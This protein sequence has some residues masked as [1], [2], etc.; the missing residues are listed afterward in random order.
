MEAEYFTSENVKADLIAFAKVIGEKKTPLDLNTNNLKNNETLCCNGE[1]VEGR[2][3]LNRAGVALGLFKDSKEAGN[4]QLSIL[5]ELLSLAGYDVKE[6]LQK[7]RKNLSIQHNKADLKAYGIVKMDAS[8]YT[9]ENVKADLEIYAKSLGE[10]KTPED[11]NTKNI[12]NIRV[13]CKNGESLKGRNY[14]YRAGVLLGLSKNSRDAQNKFSIILIFLLKMAGFEIKEYSKMDVSYFTPENVKSDLEAYANALGTNV[15]S[16]DFYSTALK[17]EEIVCCNGETVNGSKYLYRA[18][19]VL[20]IVKSSELQNKKYSTILNYLLRMAGFDVEEYKEAVPKNKEYFTVEHI[21]ADM[22]AFARTLGEGKTPSDISYNNIR[23]KEIIC[24]DNTAVKG[25]TYVVQAGRALGYGENTSSVKKKINEILIKLIEL[26]GYE[27]KVYSPMNI[28]YF[29]K[30]NVK[31]DLEA[32]AQKIGKDAIP[33]DLNTNNIRDE[34]AVCSN[35][36]SVFWFTYISRAG[37]L[38]DIWKNKHGL[39]KNR[40]RII[41]KLLNIAGYNV[42]EYID[43]QPMEADYYTKEN[44]R[45]DLEAFAKLLEPG[46]TVFNI[47]TMNISGKQI[48]CRN[49]QPMKGQKYINYAGVKL[50][51][52]KNQVEAHKRFAEVLKKLKQIAGYTTDSID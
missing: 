20:K 30:E 23:K 6:L 38:F 36:E 13:V 28:E 11:L 29:S 47:T 43:Y 24:C 12:K 9:P 40:I 7:E 18:G 3:Y 22:E 10:N 26:A 44:V 33:T 37:V 34:E 42:E 1:I 52:G 46:K 19:S 14:L 41:K 51:F 39:R 32:F 48:I 49:G 31:A 17:D 50:G 4:R 15:T 21:K 35:G 25:P 16:A 27:K 5:Y 2:K 45:A 8:Y